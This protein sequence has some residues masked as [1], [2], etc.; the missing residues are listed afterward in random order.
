MKT[1]RLRYRILKHRNNIRWGF[2]FLLVSLLFLFVLKEDAERRYASLLSVVI[3]DRNHEPIRV[4]PNGKGHYAREIDALSPSLKT[5]LLLKE[6]A[7]FFYHP[8]INPL[9]LSRA[10]YRKLTTGKSGGSSTLTEQLA[11][12]LLAT[13]N[14][15]TVRHKLRELFY[16]AGMELFMSKETILT[17]YAN[18]VYLGNQFQGFE[19]GSQAYFNTTSA[20]LTPHEISS[21]LATL[22][23]PTARNPWKE[24][25]TDYAR[26][27]YTRLGYGGDYTPP[28]TR[29]SVRMND[30]A[31]FELRSLG[32]TCAH[33]C[34]TTLDTSLSAFIRDALARIILKEYD[35]GVKNGAVVVI[36]PKRHELLAIVGTPDPE[37]TTD[38]GQINMALQPRPIGS[39]V[40]PFIYLKGFME[41]LRPYTLVD[42][43]EYR[44]SIATGYSLYPKNFDGSYHGEVTLHYALTNSLN[45]PSVKVLEYVGLPH[46]YTFLQDDLGFIPIQP[47]QSY[48]YGIALGG[49][50]MDLLTLTHYFS[51]FPSNGILHPLHVSTESTTTLSLPQARTKP[52]TKVAGDEY[53]ALVTTLLRDRLTGVEQFGLVSNLNL[54]ISEYAVKTGT[55]R[56]FHDSWVVG[57]TPDFVVGV[58]LGNS[59]NTALS[60]VSG[61][62]G[63]GVLWHDVMEYLIASPYN[64]GRPFDIHSVVQ[65]EVDGK[66][67]WGLREDMSAEHRDLLI[68]NR[69][70][71]SPHDGDVFEL[72]KENKIP[73]K[74]RAPLR[75]LVN[76]VTVGHGKELTYIPL[77]AGTYEIEGQSEYENGKR[78][79]ISIS[80]REEQSLRQ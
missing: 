4:E 38:G 66:N 13:E 25:N 37:K 51:L 71:L 69:L 34:V 14:E 7:Y 64:T 56:D 40:K 1:E 50:E 79:I 60:Q 76:G 5:A 58:W 63:A 20:Q 44:Y 67:E 24:E 54:T 41:G 49:L 2:F 10:I 59:E 8:G 68:D 22:A 77:H 31:S 16:V 32:V 29:D 74:S 42:D 65:R 11:K 17:M 61:Q 28:L 3:Y 72:G 52:A 12:N 39:T 26:S 15:R 47:L 19:T 62:S 35:R 23:N 75:W 36:D 70:I 18:T 33:T 9:S 78:E 48:Q 30:R 46:F 27:L 55:S 80:I 53:T 73:L 57:Y 21:L 6:D 43:R 45:V